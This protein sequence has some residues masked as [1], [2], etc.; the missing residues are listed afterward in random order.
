MS[1]GSHEV[2][3]GLKV[4]HPELGEG[5]VV[6]REPAGYITVFFRTHGERQV[7]EESLRF[8]TDRF[9]QIARE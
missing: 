3:L 8:V 1:Q 2:K 6:G 9:D 5:V 4:N 7:P